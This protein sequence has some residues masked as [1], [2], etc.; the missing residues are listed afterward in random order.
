MEEIKARVDALEKRF[1]TMDQNFTSLK[2]QVSTIDGYV[3]TIKDDT[4][5]LV[6]I[7]GGADAFG[8]VL[9][10]HGPRLFAFVIGSLV[11]M[12]WLDGETANLIRSLF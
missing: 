10:K 8:R 12:G 1:E 3:T 5:T 2:E 9:K 4:E 11:T 7:V 6:K